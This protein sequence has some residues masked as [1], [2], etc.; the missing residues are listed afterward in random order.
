MKN[1]KFRFDYAIFFLITAIATTTSALGA[2]CVLDR[3]IENRRHMETNNEAVVVIIVLA[4]I[5]ITVIV[6]FATALLLTG[7]LAK[8]MSIILQR[9][10]IRSDSMSY[11]EGYYIIDANQTNEDQRNFLQLAPSYRKAY[12]VCVQFTF[13]EIRE[14]L[15]YMQQHHAQHREIQK[16]F[17]MPDGISWLQPEIALRTARRILRELEENE[18]VVLVYNYA[19]P[20]RSQTERVDDTMLIQA[21]LHQPTY[22]GK[23][24]L[25]RSHLM[26]ARTRRTR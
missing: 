9:N 11:P 13:E 21:N 14:I 18:T 24:I 8:L 3:V 12:T 2:F 1:T 20:R 5:T 6:M 10:I 15:D 25:V 22:N 4:I 26:R 7:A 17:L 19:H 23:D 16:S